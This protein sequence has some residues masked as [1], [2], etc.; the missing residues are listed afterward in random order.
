MLMGCNVDVLCGLA[1]VVLSRILTVS[2][3]CITHTQYQSMNDSLQND[4]SKQTQA[5]K[6]TRSC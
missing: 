2:V 1:T 6:I 3:S 4:H 5:I